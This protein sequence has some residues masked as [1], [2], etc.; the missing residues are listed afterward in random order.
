MIC[1]WGWHNENRIEFKK[2]LI[3]KKKIENRKEENYEKYNNY[4]K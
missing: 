2:T 1:G 4:N 3:T